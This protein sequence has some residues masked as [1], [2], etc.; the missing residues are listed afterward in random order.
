MNTERGDSRQFVRELSDELHKAIE[1]QVCGTPH[2]QP[3][4]AF[5]EAL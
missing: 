1:E 4:R 2:L 3:K 5:S